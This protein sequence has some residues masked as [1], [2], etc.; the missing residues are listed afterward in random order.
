[1]EME[2]EQSTFPSFGSDSVLKI[3][4]R[5]NGMCNILKIAFNINYNH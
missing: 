4:G 5:M 2:M 3:L 1:M